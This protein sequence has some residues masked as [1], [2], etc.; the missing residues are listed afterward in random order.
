MTKYERKPRTICLDFDDTVVNFTGMLFDT[1]NKLND[2]CLYTT[3]IKDYEFESINFED[4]RGN[5]VKG[6]DIRQLYL[7]YEK[8]GL[9]AT[10]KPLGGAEQALHLMNKLGYKIIILTARA[11]EYEKQT[12]FCL[13]HNN[14]HHDLVV[15]SPSNDKA[16]ML[17]KLAKDYNI[18]AFADDKAET[19]V[20]VHE[21][22]NVNQVYVV[23]QEHNKDFDFDPEIKRISGIFEIIRDL[24]D[25]N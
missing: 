5:V 20:D 4:K 7:E 24:R 16:K 6:E 14:L 1:Y 9:Y 23:N 17:R 2:T 21:N 11:P 12:K 8:E 18:V 25:L 10:L 15:F 19:C 22:T 13:L 3:D